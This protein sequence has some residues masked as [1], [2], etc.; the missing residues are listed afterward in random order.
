MVCL[1]R[2]PLKEQKGQQRHTMEHIFSYN[3][4]IQVDMMV[5]IGLVDWKYLHSVFHHT[6]PTVNYCRNT[7]L[8]ELTQRNSVLRRCI[9]VSLTGSSNGPRMNN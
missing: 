2:V 7:S 9:V 1:F 3:A 4:V 8:F 6:N 5:K